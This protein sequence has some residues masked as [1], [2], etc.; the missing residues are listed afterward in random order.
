MTFSNPWALW[1]LLPLAVVAAWVL[2]RPARREVVV[3]SL[4]LWR[5]A[6]EALS[7]EARRRRRVNLAWVLLLAGGVAGVLACA[8]WTLRPERQGRSVAV[9]LVPSAEFADAMFELRQAADALLNRLDA[10]DRV[11]VVAPRW[12]LPDH[13]TSPAAPA[14]AGETPASRAVSPARAKELVASL[15]PVPVSAATLR[16][17]LVPP[18]EAD[19]VYV[20]GPHPAPPDA[21]RVSHMAAESG[22]SAAAPRIL[23]VAASPLSDGRVQLFVRART[24]GGAVLQIFA[25]SGAAE[26]ASP[27]TK[28][29]SQLWMSGD[30]HA[31]LELPSHDAYLVVLAP[32]DDLPPYTSRAGLP[33][34]PSPLAQ[35]GLVRREAVRVK[36]ALV[37]KDS[38]LLERL[39]RVNPAWERAEDPADAAVVVAVQAAV[40][41][42]IAGKPVLM[43]DPPSPPA[44][45]LR[46]ELRGPVLLAEAVVADDPVTTGADLARVGVRHVRPFVPV[47]VSQI[48]GLALA[49]ADDGGVLMLRSD[50]YVAATRIGAASPRR[51]DIAFDIDPRNTDWGLDPSFVVLMCN[52]VDWLAGQAT[53]TGEARYEFVTPA[54]AGPSPDWRAVTPTPAATPLP[55]PGLYRD[56][57]GQWHGVFLPTL[58]GQEEEP[59]ETPDIDALP[60]PAPKSL[61][62]PLDLWPWLLTAAA[63]FW[64][65]G[66]WLRL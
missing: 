12:A 33:A 18:A 59:R 1:L 32:F 48:Q 61:T 64:L 27:L 36:I 5:Q 50:A 28:I 66:W 20:I 62:K 8:G 43:I 25:P 26:T 11:Y 57:A 41:A 29:V 7:A 46:G 31:L 44:S 55:W 21:A 17:E 51:V 30:D 15:R 24:G 22:E 13:A 4:R 35:A 9:V 2:F 34:L 38:P 56:A 49:R 42:D 47:D 60:L 10:N 53:P 14:G 23:A 40:P 16:D 58:D 54:Q 37:G 39:I 45:W 52:A 3:G 6:R 65:A 63:I 19:H